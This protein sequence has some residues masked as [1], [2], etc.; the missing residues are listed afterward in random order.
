MVT[1]TAQS[2]GQYASVAASVL[3]TFMCFGFFL[4]EQH[5]PHVYTAFGS[6]STFLT[7]V[8]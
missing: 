3:D 6:L 8:F 5:L 4:E 2:T 1:K 7:V